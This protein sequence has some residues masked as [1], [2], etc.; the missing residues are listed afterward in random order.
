[1]GED[2]SSFGELDVTD[3]P[4]Y[5]AERAT[6]D[7]APPRWPDAWRSATAAVRSSSERSL[8]AV[9]ATVQA[10]AA[11]TPCFARLIDVPGLAL[12]DALPRW[13]ARVARAGTAEVDGHLLLRPPA[14]AGTTWSLHGR[15]RHGRLAGVP[16]AV[17]L[18]A[19]GTT[20]TRLTMTPQV[21][22]ATSKRYF[23]IGNRALDQLAIDLARCAV[24][25]ARPR[26]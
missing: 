18:W 25:G 19:H 2:G 11:I 14:L 5:V 24:G 3:L 22:V 23:A 10:S 15:L 20:F 12:A 17:D 9:A 26:G 8:G 16:V 1:M 21:R 13:W 6:S 4:L 7:R